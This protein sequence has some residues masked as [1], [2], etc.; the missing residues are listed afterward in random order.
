M[1]SPR[2]TK[3]RDRAQPAGKLIFVLGGA[4]SGKSEVALRLGQGD[5][6]KAF[7]ATGQALDDEMM[8]R[9]TRHQ[10]TRPSD[11]VT[12]EVPAKLVNW[13]DRKGK[14]YQS[15]V[16]DCLMLW[17]NN[18]GGKITE[19]MLVEEIARLLQAIRKVRAK[20]VLVSNELGMSLVPVGPDVRRFRDLAGKMNQLVADE[21]DEVHF[22][23]SG[24]TLRLK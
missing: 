16:I 12:F 6:P 23:V 8:A 22:V 11:W 2:R 24:Q 9:I 20:V 17:L 13:L 1:S 5:R 4:A 10:S 15:I 19:K 3:K 18:L 21:A 7:V 14:Q